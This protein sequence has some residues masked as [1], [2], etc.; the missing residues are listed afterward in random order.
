MGI[1]RELQ[2]NLIQVDPSEGG[3]TRAE[4]GRRHETR[5]RWI[6]VDDREGVS[7]ILFDTM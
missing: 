6:K 2:C 7:S 5:T 3:T 4:H 1:Q